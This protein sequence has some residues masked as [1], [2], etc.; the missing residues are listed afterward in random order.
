MKITA[1]RATPVNIPFTAPYV[2]SHGSVRSLTKTIV[3][4]D[5]DEARPVSAKSPTAIGPATS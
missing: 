2:F 3:E 1:V 4:I 5:T